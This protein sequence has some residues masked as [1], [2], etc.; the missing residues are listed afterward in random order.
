V[1]ADQPS[2]DAAGLPRA[3]VLLICLLLLGA[4]YVVAILRGPAPVQEMRVVT[5]PPPATV[6]DTATE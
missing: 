4:G 5:Y 6:P 2:K 1:S 3:P